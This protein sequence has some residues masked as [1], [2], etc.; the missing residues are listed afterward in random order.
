MQQIVLKQTIVDKIKESGY[1]FGEIATN[2]GVAPASLPR[3]LYKNDPRLT[4][5]G[6]L[7]IIKDHLRLEDESELLEVVS[8]SENKNNTLSSIMQENV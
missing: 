6:I 2:I 8:E 5:A 7:K 1:L 4:Q 3:L